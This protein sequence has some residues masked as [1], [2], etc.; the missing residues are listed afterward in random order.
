MS[1]AS[2]FMTLPSLAQTDYCAFSIH[3]GE[4][5][6]SQPSEYAEPFVEFEALIKANPKLGEE[7]SYYS[8][9]L[10]LDDLKELRTGVDDLIKRIEDSQAEAEQARQDS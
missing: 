2:V 3:N 4:M 6:F 7:G 1:S 8:T 10:T 9:S 5:A